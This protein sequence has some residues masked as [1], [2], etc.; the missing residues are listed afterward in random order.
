MR[1]GEGVGWKWGEGCM[2]M[3][4]AEGQIC[5]FKETALFILRWD[6][7][8]WENLSDHPCLTW[9]LLNTQQKQDQVRKEC[10]EKSFCL[11]TTWKIQDFFF[12]HDEALF[13]YPSFPWPSCFIILL[14]NL[15]IVRE[16]V[17]PSVIEIWVEW[18]MFQSNIT[19]W[20]E[21]SFR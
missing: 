11:G 3:W 8:V 12:F 21:T 1:C 17:K 19:T 5:A 10:G 14:C 2:G 6:F 9:S 13:L 4:C 15:Y 7:T 20:N 18:R 16:G